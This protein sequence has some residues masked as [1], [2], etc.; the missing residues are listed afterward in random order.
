[1]EKNIP[2]GSRSNLDGT[3]DQSRA[4]KGAR[5]QLR[6][7]N[8]ELIK[9]V[10]HD[11]IEALRRNRTVD[12]VSLSPNDGAAVT[13]CLCKNC[14]AWDAPG[15]DKIEMWGPKEPTQH[16]SLSDRYVRFYSEVG[17]IV[18]REFPQRNLGAYAYGGY[19]LPPLHEK[20][21][22][23]VVLGFVGFAYLNEGYRT[24]SRDAWLKWSEMAS[25]IFLRPNALAAGMGSPTVHV[26]RLA[27][28]FRFCLDH[29]M[30]AC[31]FDCCYHH[32][33]SDGLNYYV[34]AKLL[35]DPKTDVD[36]AIADYCRAG[37]GPAAGTVREYFRHCETNLEAFAC[38]SA[39]RKPGKDEV[40][41]F[42]EWTPEEFFV[43]SNLLLDRATREAS[44]DVT[45]QQRVAFLRKA[46]QLG[47]IRHRYWVARSA[48]KN[49]DRQAVQRAKLI[50]EE[51]MKWY[52]KLG[53]S[54]AINV[55]NLEFYH[56][57]F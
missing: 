15:G 37:F 44:A 49:G 16:V 12:C 54:W 8:P 33:A 14:E 10:A 41:V 43:K 20:L 31:D 1:M 48:A 55:A 22:P 29:K 7:S 25:R 11:A 6:V 40:A 32:C 5:S 26:H 51:R 47:E 4:Q 19:Q 36:A 45:I 34:L 24:Q 46:L 50:E 56:G 3:R 28:D 18:A 52:Q 39:T 2:S 13:H 38:G 17:A 57:R 23:N 9:Q 21:H 42:A 27:E 35:W 30:M 53:I